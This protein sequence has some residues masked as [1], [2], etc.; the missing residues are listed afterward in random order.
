VPLLD[1]AVRHFDA[2]NHTNIIPIVG[3]EIDEEVPRSLFIPHTVAA[4]LVDAHM[5]PWEFLKCISDKVKI[6]P[7]LD[8]KMPNS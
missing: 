7:R 6:G 3:S 2:P 1:S 5:L 4:E 8:R